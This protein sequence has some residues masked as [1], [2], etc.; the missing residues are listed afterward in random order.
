MEA[1]R[2]PGFEGRFAG[3]E[4]RRGMERDLALR[5]LGQLGGSAGAGGHGAGVHESMGMPVMGAGPLGA[6]GLGGSGLGMA[7]AAGPLRSMSGPAGSMG[8]T[9]GPRGGPLVGGLPSTGFG[10]GNLLTDAAFALNRETRQGGILSFWSRGARSHFSGQDGA[11]SLGGDVQTTM[12]GAE[13]PATGCRSGNCSSARRA[14]G[15]APQSTAATTGSATAS[16]C[17]TGAT[18]PRAK[19]RCA[20][21]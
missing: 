9:V 17:L 2:Q 7:A 18:E 8:A 6:P 11:L 3:R 20:P 12:F 10:G 19:R 13:M 5:F 15:S 1:P 14:S 21:S 4:L 16:E